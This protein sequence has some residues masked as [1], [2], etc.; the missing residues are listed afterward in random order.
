MKKRSAKVGLP[1]GSL[2]YVGEE[3]T[4]RTRVSVIDFDEQRVEEREIQRIED[5]QAFKESDS[6]SWIDVDET[7]CQVPAVCPPA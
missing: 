6:V 5:C 4:Q 3:R 7:S 2:V 1:P